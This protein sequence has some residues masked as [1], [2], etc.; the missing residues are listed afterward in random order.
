[1]NYYNYFTEIEDAFIRRRGK[2]LFLS[3][4]DWALIEGWQE[5]GIPLHI[6]IRAIET[7]FDGFDKQ[8]NQNRTIKS[9]FYCREEVEAQ[10]AEWTTAQVGGHG[11]NGRELD[12]QFS[13]EAVVEHIEKAIA[14]LKSINETSLREDVDRA[15]ARLEELLG[16]LGDDFEYIDRTLYDIES[17]LDRAM[18]SNTEKERLKELKKQVTSQLK[19]Y[20][21][22]MDAEAY[23]NTFELM[24]LKCLREDLGIPRLG[25]FYL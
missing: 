18:L 16:N 25:L 8:P 12:G 10:F 7:V 23:K 5:R 20:K 13:K 11:V 3:P 9:L 1:L 6:V 15:V 24:L 4:L 14:A 2:N 21:N 19:L 22:A 17:F